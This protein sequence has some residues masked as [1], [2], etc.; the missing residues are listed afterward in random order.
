MYYTFFHM[1]SRAKS[2]R[3][4]CV[5]AAHVGG[6]FCKQTFYGADDSSITLMVSMT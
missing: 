1:E 4:F 5:H 3:D 2:F 6:E